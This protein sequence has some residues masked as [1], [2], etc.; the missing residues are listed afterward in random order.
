MSTGK[1]DATQR[2]VAVL[3][4]CFNE[5]GAVGAVVEA[6]RKELPDATIYVYDN[7]SSDDTAEEACRSGAIVRKETSQGKGNVV[8]RMFADVEADFYILIDG[9]NTYDAKSAPRLLDRIVE[10]QA[11]LV[12]AVRKP[13]DGTKAYRPGHQFGNVL[14]S[15]IAGLFFGQKVSDMLSGYRVFSRR[16]VKSFPARSS[17]FEI[18]TELTIHTLSLNLPWLEVPAPFYERASGTESKLRTFRDGF[19]VLFMIFYLF[20]EFR[21][22]AFF[23]SIGLVL[24]VASVSF[25][26]PIFQEY[27]E[28][29]LV[30]RLPT[31]V[32][33]TGLMICALLSFFCGLIL[34]SV[35]AQGL[36]SKRL[37]Y[38]RYSMSGERL[39]PDE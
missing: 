7:N 9:D 18:E 24:A 38:L 22:L 33:V 12:V 20:K 3:I 31:A 13:V 19:G 6:F 26:I 23:G 25:S 17:G 35:A 1:W 34:D 8:R 37:N 36:E 21:P 27:F 14:L 15:R 2:R 16:F 32:L 10:G 30:P 29:G 11:D 4:P 28:T 39:D 5:E